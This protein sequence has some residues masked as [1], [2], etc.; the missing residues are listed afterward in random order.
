MPRIYVGVIGGHGSGKSSFARRLADF[1]GRESD[2]KASVIPIA[3]PLKRLAADSLGLQVL[4]DQN[5]PPSLRRLLQGFGESRRS[6][7]KNAW[8]RDWANWT[9][10]LHPDADIVISPDTYH[11]NEVAMMDYLVATSGGEM[12]EDGYGTPVSVRQAR[13]ILG[14]LGHRAALFE[15]RSFYTEFDAF[16]VH[17]Y[18]LHTPLASLDADAYDEFVRKVG[19]DVMKNAASAKAFEREV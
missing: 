10:R 7:D 15:T 12:V 11:W 4:P 13:E 2:Y 9:V 19:G 8:V 5:K 6:L 16:G 1:L 3:A 18:Y 14:Y 17:V